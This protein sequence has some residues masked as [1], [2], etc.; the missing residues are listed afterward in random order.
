MVVQNKYVIRVVIVVV[1]LMYSL[2]VYL[3]DGQ[4][5]LLLLSNLDLPLLYLLVFYRLRKQIVLHLLGILLNRLNLFSYRRSTRLDNLHI[6][7]A[8]LLDLAYV[9]GRKLNLPLQIIL[10]I[11]LSLMFLDR[12][13]LLFYPINDRILLTFQILLPLIIHSGNVPLQNMFHVMLHLTLRLLII[14]LLPLLL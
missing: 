7:L 3:A 13:N 14:P 6:F 1:T 4:R 5:I 8:F 11:V 10:R 9:A 2:I 12:S